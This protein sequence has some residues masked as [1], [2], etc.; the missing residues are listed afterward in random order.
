MRAWMI[1]GVVLVLFMFS[2]AVWSQTGTTS[3]RGTVSDSSGGLVAGA[4]VLLANPATGFSRS[5]KTDS[6]GGYQFA[7]LPPAAYDL[8]I[9]GDGFAA[10]KQSQLTLH[11]GTPATL[12][13]SL[14]VAEASTRIEVSTAA[15]L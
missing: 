15:P 5:T 9:S 3:L 14:K 8:T 4:T 2:S 1:T 10:V 6:Q 13:V 7:E 12:N 11:V